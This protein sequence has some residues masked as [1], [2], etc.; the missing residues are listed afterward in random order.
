MKLPVGEY[1]IPEDCTAKIQGGVVYVFRKL[2]KGRRFGQR[3]HCR[4]C[5]YRVDG[6]ACGVSMH[7]TKVCKKRPKAVLWGYNAG[8]TYYAA[9]EYGEICDKFK[10]K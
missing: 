8:K 9:P 6:Y 1:E 7:K 4:D 10:E 5:R 3:K 2:P